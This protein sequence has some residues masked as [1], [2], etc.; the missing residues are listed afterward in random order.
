MRLLKEGLL[1]TQDFAEKD[2]VSKQD[3]DLR[4]RLFKSK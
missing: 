2:P 4:V 1:N 3:M